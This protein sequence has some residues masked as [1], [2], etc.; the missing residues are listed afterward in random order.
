MADGHA[1]ESVAAQPAPALGSAR[2]R[3][4]READ[5]VR[6]AA[7]TYT[8]R[9]LAA[10]SRITGS[11]PAKLNNEA[12]TRIVAGA[13]QEAATRSNRAGRIACS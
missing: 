12:H 8:A 7:P 3:G 4:A 9:F 11:Y 5:R 1:V 13:F 6:P 2:A 10:S